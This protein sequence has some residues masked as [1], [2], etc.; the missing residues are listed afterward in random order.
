[1]AGDYRLA[2]QLWTSAG[3]TRL[4]QQSAD[5]PEVRAAA[6]GA[7]YCWTQLKDPAAAIEAGPELVRLLRA[8]PSVDPHHLRLAQQRLELLHGA[9]GAALR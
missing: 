4:V 8:L 6:A 5:A 7:L 2:T 1:M 9:A 3:R